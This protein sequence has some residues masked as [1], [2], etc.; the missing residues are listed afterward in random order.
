MFNIHMFSA[1]YRKY[2]LVF[3]YYTKYISRARNSTSA[4]WNWCVL[5]YAITHSRGWVQ[6]YAILFSLFVTRNMCYKIVNVCRAEGCTTTPF[7][8]RF[9]NEGRPAT[10]AFFT[11]HLYNLIF[12][13]SIWRRHRFCSVLYPGCETYL[14]NSNPYSAQCTSV[15]LSRQ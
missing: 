9:I 13:L 8:C 5:I 7:N 11:F 14:K 1:Y 15:V 12:L 4:I 3:I 2:F 6:Y 10:A